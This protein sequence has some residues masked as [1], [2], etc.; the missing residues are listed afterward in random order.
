L[1]LTCFHGASTNVNVANKKQATR[2]RVKMT[3]N[4]EQPALIIDLGSFETKFG[5]YIQENPTV[6]PTVVSFDLPLPKDRKPTFSVGKEALKTYKLNSQKRNKQNEKGSKVERP[7]KT[8]QH[9]S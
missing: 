6:I 7:K 3:G 4:H 8:N 5:V 9:R 2:S 1:I